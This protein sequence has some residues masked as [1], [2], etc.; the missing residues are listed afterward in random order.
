[1][2]TCPSSG[3]T[4]SSGADQFSVVSDP[5]THPL[6]PLRPPGGRAG[7][8]GRHL[9]RRAGDRAGP[10]AG[11]RVGAAL[12]GGLRGPAAGGPLAGRRPAT[13]GPPADAGDPRPGR[14]RHLC[15]QPLFPGRAGAAAGQPH[16]ADHRA[17]PGGDDL[18]GR[19]AAAR[20]AQ[21]QALA[22]RG[23]GPGRGVGGDHARQPD[24]GAGPVHRPG[25]DADVRRRVRLGGLHPHRP[26]G[27]QGPD[28]P[29]HPPPPTPRC[30]ARRC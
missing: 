18:P 30:G 19:L 9:H 7:H 25:R 24:C 13:A 6:V 1:M 29:G 20:T 10:A 16:L 22:G 27:A 26:C 21:P 3:R 4:A 5:S 8:L 2:P 23:A 14:H 12:P 28:G 15:L 11:F 17:Q